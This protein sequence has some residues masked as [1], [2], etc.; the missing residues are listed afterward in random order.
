MC[1]KCNYTGGQGRWNVVIGIDN[2]SMEAGGM[3][4]PRCIGVLQL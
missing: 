2:A 3:V 4:E 1:N